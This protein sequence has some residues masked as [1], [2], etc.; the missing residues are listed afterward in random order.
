[1]L[2]VTQCP[3]LLL[4]KLR[5][6]ILSVDNRFDYINTTWKDMFDTMELELLE[7]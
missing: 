4:I 3:L 5:F 7:I 1:M 2:R 6:K